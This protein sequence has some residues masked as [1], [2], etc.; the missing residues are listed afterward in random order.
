MLVKVKAVDPDFDRIP[1]GG[2]TD[3][4]KRDARDES[5]RQQFAP[6]RCASLGESHYVTSVTGVKVLE[7]RLHLS[8]F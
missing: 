7:S 2:L 4:M 6:M 5:H 3:Y 1:Q 8:V